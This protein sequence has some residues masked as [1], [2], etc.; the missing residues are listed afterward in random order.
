MV[1]KDWWCLSG[2]GC[3]G[4]RVCLE[5]IPNPSEEGGLTL[6]CSFGEAWGESDSVDWI[7][8][9]GLDPSVPCDL[10]VRV[11]G[12]GRGTTP[13]ECCCRRNTDLSKLN[14]V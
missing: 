5:A 2:L 10:E 14:P 3:R 4:T 7:S 8:W 6:S 11:L 12:W 13:I 9:S 1:S